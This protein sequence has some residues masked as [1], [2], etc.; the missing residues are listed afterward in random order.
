VVLAYEVDGIDRESAS[1]GAIQPALV[2]LHARGKDEQD[3]SDH[4]EYACEL[5]Q[6]IAGF[7]VAGFARPSAIQL[8]RKRIRTMNRAW[9]EIQKYSPLPVA[10]ACKDLSAS[11]VRL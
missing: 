7:A 1:D 11:L 6:S 5:G 9:Y 8:Q 4:C 10:Q 3:D 2:E